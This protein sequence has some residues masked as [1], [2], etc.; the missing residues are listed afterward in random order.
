MK[1]LLFSSAFICLSLKKYEKILQSAEA[2]E[3]GGTARKWSLSEQVTLPQKAKF[4]SVFAYHLSTI[5]DSKLPGLFSVAGHGTFVRLLWIV[6]VCVLRKSDLL[7]LCG[8]QQ[9]SLLSESP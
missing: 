7:A 9:R 1:P 5:Q 6:C 8:C 3:K 4:L 2:Y